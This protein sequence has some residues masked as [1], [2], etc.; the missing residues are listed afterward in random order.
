MVYFQNN[1]VAQNDTQ[2]I[3]QLQNDEEFQ[4]YC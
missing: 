2:P 3:I 1:I 4:V